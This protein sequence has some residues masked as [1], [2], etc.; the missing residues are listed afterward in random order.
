MA[1]DSVAGLLGRSFRVAAIDGVPTLP[2]PVAD[3]E[4]GADGRVVGCATVNRLFGPYTL[5]GATLTCGPLAGTMMAGPPEA[6]DQEQRL[7]RALSGPL[8]VV[9]DGSG[10]RVELRGNAGVAL[11]LVPDDRVELI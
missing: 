6:M 8:T 2:T 7:H 1:S 9:L 4:F 11:V 3:L 10:D 5:D